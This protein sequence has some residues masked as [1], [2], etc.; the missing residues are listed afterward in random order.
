MQSPDLDRVYDSRSHLWLNPRSLTDEETTWPEF[1]EIPGDPAWPESL[2]IPDD[3]ED[4]P[5]SA[6]PSYEGDFE[7]R[8]LDSTIWNPEINHDMLELD[9]RSDESRSSHPNDDRLRSGQI[10]SQVQ[11]VDG[12]DQ[13]REANNRPS[14]FPNVSGGNRLSTAQST[15]NREENAGVAE[16]GWQNDSLDSDNAWNEQPTGIFVPTDPLVI[17]LLQQRMGLPNLQ[18]QRR[19]GFLDVPEGSWDDVISPSAQQQ[20]N[21]EEESES[22]S[23]DEASSDEVVSSGRRIPRVVHLKTDPKIPNAGAE[24]S[25]QKKGE[26]KKKREN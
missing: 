25:E 7:S 1:P 11:G 14:V 17:R 9:S 24:I 3:E 8:Q 15:Q 16:D 4:W 19:R 6:E 26:K 2:E 23:E 22:E 20:P 12:T 21:Q 18:R 10:Q 5:D 13:S